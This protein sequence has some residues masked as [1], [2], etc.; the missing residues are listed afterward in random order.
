MITE[1]A[2]YSKFV[3]KNNTTIHQIRDEYIQ[4]TL[5]MNNSDVMYVIKNADD[6]SFSV[7]LNGVILDRKLDEI[8]EIFIEQNTSGFAYFGRPQ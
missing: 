4:G 6:N 3:I 5:R 2:D 8:R 1:N 7:V